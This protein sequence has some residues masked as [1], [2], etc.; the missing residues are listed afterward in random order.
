MRI[1]LRERGHEIERSRREPPLSSAMRSKW[2]ASRRLSCFSESRTRACARQCRVPPPRRA[3]AA[4]RIS[5]IVARWLK[6]IFNYR[7]EMT[8]PL[9]APRHRAQDWREAPVAIYAW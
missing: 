3:L 8:A 4:W 7:V 1:Y 2:S 9:L 5:F 6:Q